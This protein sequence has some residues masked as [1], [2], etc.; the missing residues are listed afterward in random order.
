MLSV[1]GDGWVPLWLWWAANESHNR[2]IEIFSRSAETH[3]LLS[4]CQLPF[5]VM[6]I[7]IYLKFWKYLNLYWWSNRPALFWRL[8]VTKI[9][10]R[11][12]IF[13]NCWHLDKFSSAWGFNP[14]YKLSLNKKWVDYPLIYRLSTMLDFPFGTSF[15]VLR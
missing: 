7:S 12:F 14:R 2:L 4:K 5:Y 3:S 1:R 8:E 9:C 11:R 6:I 13:F 10:F 15:W